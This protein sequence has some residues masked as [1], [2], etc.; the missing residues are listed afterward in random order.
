MFGW[1]RAAWRLGCCLIVAV[2]ISQPADAAAEEATAGHDALEMDWGWSSLVLSEVLELGAVGS[3]ERPV[4]YDLVGWVGGAYNRVWAKA[5]GDQSTTTRDG[6]TELQLLYGRLISPF[7]D[8][9]VGVRFDAI[10][11]DGSRTLRPLLALGVQGLAPGWFEL[12]PTLFVSFKGDVS[13][14]VTASYDLFM[15]QRLVLQPRIEAGAAVQSVPEFHVGYGL[16]HIESG[17]RLRYEF[18]REFAPYIGMSWDRQFGRTA[19]LAR[20][21][22]GA[23]QSELLVV[24][25]LRLWR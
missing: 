17:L 15:T 13:A 18:W 3:D 7:W 25:G 14:N 12:E 16:N 2:A 6:A 20:A 19:E 24:A 5:D 8:A 22:A 1:S 10:Y 4:R 23:P 11:G 9:Q 21:R